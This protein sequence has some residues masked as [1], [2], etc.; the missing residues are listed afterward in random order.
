M[1]E[2]LLDQGKPALARAPLERALALRDASP[3]EAIDTGKT[4]FALAR[5][6]GR[7]DLAI[8]ARKELASA[9][10]LGERRAEEV[11]AWLHARAR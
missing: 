5:A 8:A 9:G 3:G 2:T 6:T 7:E 11:D 10:P 1:G 4:R